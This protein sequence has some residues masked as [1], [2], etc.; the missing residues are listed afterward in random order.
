[1]KKWI[2]GSVI[3]IVVAII[4][5][6]IIINWGKTTVNNGD[7]V[8]PVTIKQITKSELIET[9]LCFGTVKA[10]KQVDI[11]AKVQGRVEE[12][13]IKEG[14][15]VK[16][17]DVLAVLE[18][19][20]IESQMEQSEAGLNAAKAQLKQA[21][22][23]SENLA[24]E[25]RRITRLSK[26]GAISVSRKEQMETQYNASL[27]QKEAIEAQIKQM[28][29]LLKQAKINLDEAH[30]RASISGIV[31]QRYIDLGD[32]VTPM[33]PLF[34]IIQINTVKIT[35]TIP[36][37]ILSKVRMGK[38]MSLITVDAYADKTFNGV[39]SYVAPAVDPRSRNVDIEIELENTDG[40]LKP[41]MFSRIELILDHKKDIIAI[42]KDLL[43]Y[44]LPASPSGGSAGQS[45][46]S[47]T[48]IKGYAVFLIRDN[49]AKK[50]KVKPGIYSRGLVEIK[51]G[52]SEGDSIITTVG[53]H[54]FDGS[55]V[56]V[57]NSK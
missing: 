13:V 21:E 30:I 6:R 35:T 12:L 27:A 4:A 43:I 10:I 36:E 55:K 11:Y 3:I 16:N 8:I 17:G 54:I 38:T 31:S 22:V 28:E 56:E 19:S 46:M 49:I 47:G 24:K 53:P 42:P 7:K 2:I 23:N 14:Q 45:G 20:A 33:K 51:E 50:I 40:V 41:G 29:A 26:E 32:M 34:T 5:I 57:V 48:D 1:M 39:V 44:D 25:L 37:T 52:L 18:C 15:K 9:T